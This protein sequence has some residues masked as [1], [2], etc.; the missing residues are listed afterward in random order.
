MSDASTDASPVGETTATEAL[1]SEATRE[2][3]TA[4]G[5]ALAA[6]DP[7]QLAPLLANHVA[8]R[9]PGRH[10]AAGVHHGRD[11][12]MDALVS[13]ADERV[14]DICTEVT[15]I[16]VDARRAFVVLRTT[17]RL[18]DGMVT[19]PIDVE[20]ALHLQTDGERILAITE[21]NDDQHA[22]DRV[23]GG[24]PSEAPER[25]GRWRHWWRRTTR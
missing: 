17:G 18:D 3:A 19:V 12:V 21:Y 23:L 1:A 13:P 24:A 22:L 20:V 2:L 4:F 11:R 16:V 5:S 6:G 7:K 25:T 14:R 10:A 9:T 15:E 8:C